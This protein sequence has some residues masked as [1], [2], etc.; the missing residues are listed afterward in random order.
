MC[1]RLFEKYLDSWL[2]NFEFL[3]DDGQTIIQKNVAI[4]YVKANFNMVWLACI[5]G[6]TKV[7]IGNVNA[8]TGLRF[9]LI[10]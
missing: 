5:V 10:V 8:D 3:L 7:E 1:P 6:D 2:T 9:A 4:L